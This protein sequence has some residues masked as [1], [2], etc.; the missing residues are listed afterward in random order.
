MTKRLRPL[1]P[2]SDMSVAAWLECQ[3]GIG[4]REA[5]VNMDD[6]EMLLKSA[7]S[8]ILTTGVRI[9]RGAARDYKEWRVL[10]SA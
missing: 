8:V 4:M 2:L 1:P 7:E 6:L 3:S 5:H 9:L 10:V